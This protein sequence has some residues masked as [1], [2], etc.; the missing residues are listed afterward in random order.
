MTTPRAR[1]AAAKAER[2]RAAR[3]TEPV[4]SSQEDRP[5][6]RT[7]AARSAPVRV[8]L[9]LAPAL[10]SQ[11]NQWCAGTAL[12]LGLGRV[13][14]VQVMR[15]LMRRMLAD[16]ELADHVRNEIRRER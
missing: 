16:E 10:H 5:V 13:T 7:A 6:P 11:L 1:A 3:T 9:D 12:E 4:E 2:M 15:V 8:T 14:T